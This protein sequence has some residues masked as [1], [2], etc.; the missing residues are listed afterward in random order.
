VREVGAHRGDPPRSHPGHEAGDRIAREGRHGGADEVR[1]DQGPG[2]RPRG[3]WMLRE[4]GEREEDEGQEDPT[5]GDV[6][7]GERR[8]LLV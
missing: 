1:E 4:E 7:C 3:P 8:A 6:R 2:R 5:E